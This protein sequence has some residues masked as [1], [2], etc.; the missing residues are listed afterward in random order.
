VREQITTG[1]PL[2]QSFAAASF[3]EPQAGEIVSFT[4]N[5]ARCWRETDQESG[6]I[7]QRLPAECLERWL[8]CALLVMA[9]PPGGT[10][11]ARSL[12]AAQLARGPGVRVK[13][14][15]LSSLFRKVRH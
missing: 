13:G 7:F 1:T 3:F 9:S 10:P 14:L 11:G 2:R 15:Q 6:E 4:F 12:F 8:P 5:K